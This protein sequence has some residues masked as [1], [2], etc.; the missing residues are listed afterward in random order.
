MMMMVTEYY[1]GD[2]KQGEH[3]CSEMQHARGKIYPQNLSENM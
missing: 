2:K 1:Y 3:Y